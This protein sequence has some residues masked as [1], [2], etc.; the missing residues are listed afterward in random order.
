[1]R[2]LDKLKEAARGAFR[3]VKPARGVPS[4]PAE[5]VRRRLLAISGKGI[6]TSEDDG[7][8]VVAWSAKGTGIGESN[9]QYLYRALR[10]S[11]DADKTTPY[12]RARTHDTHASLEGGGISLSK[13][14]TRGQQIGFEDIDVVAWPGPEGDEPADEQF[15]FSWSQLRKPAIEAVTGAG[16]TYDPRQL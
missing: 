6:R 4:A 15:R 8:I 1:M 7:E 13:E 16:W 11:L 2:L 14:W 12:A 3:P 10:I 5:E 9:V